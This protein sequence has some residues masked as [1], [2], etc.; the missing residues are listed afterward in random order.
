MDYAIARDEAMAQLA[1]SKRRAYLALLV[2][3]VLVL[4]RAVRR[5]ER[6][7]R[8]GGAGRRTAA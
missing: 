3:S 8:P 4:I 6:R 2:G 1:R 7:A 5:Q